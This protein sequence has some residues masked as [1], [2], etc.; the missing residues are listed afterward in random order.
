MEG[1]TSTL[2]G[3]LGPHAWTLARKKQK[4]I[5]II[6][7]NKTAQVYLSGD[8]DRSNILPIKADILEGIHPGIKSVEFHLEDVRKMDA[9]SMAMI[10]IVVKYLLSKK[11]NSR[12]SG[13]T[14]EYLDLA[15]ILGL[16]LMAEVEGKIQ[17]TTSYRAR[18]S[19]RMKIKQRG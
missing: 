13:L 11:I 8:I 16:H 7:E 19:E 2:T 14:G 17:D 15:T 12:V 4:M 6:E 10:V 5:Y 9:P 1:N 3:I 18:R